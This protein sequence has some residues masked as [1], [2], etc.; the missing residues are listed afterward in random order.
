MP[1]IHHI[2]YPIDL[3]ADM[4][5]SKVVLLS[6]L[7]LLSACTC[8]PIKKPGEDTVPVVEGDGPLKDV[9]FA[10]DSYQLDTAAKGTLDANAAWLKANPAA[11]V[12]VEG[13]CDERGTNEYNMVLGQ[14]R[15]RASFNYLRGLGVDANRMSTISYGEEQPLDPAHNDAAWTRNRRDHFRVSQ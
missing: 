8:K 15:A 14:N 5:R 12:T 11:K 6:A 1:Q 3:E 4:F 10:F 9:Y 7:A 2:F 13:H